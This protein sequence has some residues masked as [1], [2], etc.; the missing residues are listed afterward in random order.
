MPDT[1]LLTNGFLAQYACQAVI[2]ALV[3]SLM[4]TLSRW[5]GSGL[6]R[7][8]GISWAAHAVYVACAGLALHAVIIGCG[9]L[10]PLRLL[11]S[12]FSLSSA[13]LQV[14][15]LVKGWRSEQRGDNDV[16]RRHVLRVAA[17]VVL[18]ALAATVVLHF[19]AD[20]RVRFL[21][22]VSA[23][24]L[25]LAAAQIWIGFAVLRRTSLIRS[26]RLWLGFGMIAFGV[27][28]LHY[29]YLTTF[30]Y[31]TVTYE[32]EFLLQFIELGLHT[33]IASP[34]L[35]WVC[36]RFADKSDSQQKEL[37][38]RAS[39]LEEQDVLL[40]RRQRLSAIGRMAAGVAHDFNNVLAVI[41]GWTD[42]L[43][44][45]S[46]LD[47]L[48]REGVTEID[49]AAKQA[50]AISQ[51]LMLFGG[52]RQLDP[53]L[54]SVTEAVSEARRLTPKLDA[55]AFEADV[56]EDLPMVRGDRPMLVAA[57]QNLLIN[58]YDA[59]E[60]DGGVRVSAAA[61]AVDKDAAAAL[62]IEPGDYVRITVHDDGHGMPADV[63][64]QVFEPFF[65]TKQH[66]NGLGLPSVHGFARQTGGTVSIESAPGQGTSIHLYLP[67]A[68]EHAQ[69]KALA[70]PAVELPN[71]AQSGQ[72]G[73]HRVLV[74]DDEPSI[75]RHVSRVLSRAGFEVSSEASPERALKHALELG[76]ALTVLV[77]DVRM[78]GMSGIQ[79][80]NA[81]GASNPKL[82]VLFVTGFADD[83]DAG[84]LA[85]A[86]RPAVLQKPIS[87]ETLLDAVRGL[88]L[89]PARTRADLR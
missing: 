40:A 74:V 36:M 3:A 87:S 78:P 51:Q 77:T 65:T 28:H 44:H 37:K 54:I 67:V 68:T 42:I 70:L 25:I 22:K 30:H 63:R 38:R 84:E 14:Y 39:M 49:A 46:K 69:T 24:G 10:H 6:M 59:T 15:A 29:A 83:V 73:R 82:R 52:K 53:T 17:G 41:Q 47:D 48:G 33:V 7:W 27:K 35:L 16:S 61:K 88:M 55:R 34:M 20:S 12:V 9:E 21:S 50:G 1:T 23:R 18:L 5:Q 86:A 13:A 85:L 58:A 2:C 43:R 32:Q 31:G 45:D 56:A 62:A 89:Q 8:W 72:T 19:F 76:D 66:G 79:L 71:P 75:A 4:L 64:S 11:L 57:L 60:H 26:I 81:I 80:A